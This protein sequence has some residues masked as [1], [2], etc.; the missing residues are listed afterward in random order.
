MRPVPRFGGNR[1]TTVLCIVGAIA[2]AILLLGALHRCA[3]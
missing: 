2:V 3:F 1:I